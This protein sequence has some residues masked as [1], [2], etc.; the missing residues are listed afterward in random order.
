MLA[1]ERVMT[2]AARNLL[3]DAAQKWGGDQLSPADPL[4]K[5]KEQ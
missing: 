5:Q 2:P 1:S 4:F 3:V